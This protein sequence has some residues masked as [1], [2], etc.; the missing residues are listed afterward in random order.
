[1]TKHGWI[2]Y[3]GNL[4]GTKFLDFAEMIQA[5]ATEKGSQTTIIKNNHIHSLI[6]AQPDPINL[7]YNS[8]YGP[9]PDYVVFTDKDIYLAQQLERLKIPVFNSAQAIAVSDD[10]IA[11][12]QALAANSLQ[13][14]KTIIAPKIFV[15]DQLGSIQTEAIIS[16]LELPLII[17]EAFGSF[18]EQVYLIH[19]QQELKEKVNQL[20][21]TAYM[22]QEF[23]QT[24]YGRD[25]RLQVI[26]DQV[27]AAMERNSK[28][29]FRANITAGGTMKPYQPSQ[30]EKELAVAGAKAVGAD[31]AGVDLLFGEDGPIICEINSNAHIRN[32][33]DCTG[34]NAATY[35]IDYI[36][37]TLATR[38]D[39]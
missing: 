21:G 6:G 33:L 38:G 9:Y 16:H 26:G 17:K 11:T 10:K 4:P 5:A 13:I 7:I 29:D 12:Y 25:L 30:H 20:A 32:L 8:N 37:N 3:N 23:I 14:P 2:I 35:M 15:K 19:T 18:G 27:V 1:M 31:F 36:L 34:I 39:Q 24:S 22:F 28:D